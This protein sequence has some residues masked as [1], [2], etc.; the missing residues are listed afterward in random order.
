MTI[1]V[2][3]AKGEPITSKYMVEIEPE[4]GGGVG[5]WGGSANVNNEGTVEFDGIPPGRYV[6][7]GRPNP[8][9][10]Q[11]KTDRMLVDIKEES[12]DAIKLIAK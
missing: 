9:R 8:G 3:D 6:I 5:T 7:W 10:E 12:Q 11:D 1:F 4:E 2:A